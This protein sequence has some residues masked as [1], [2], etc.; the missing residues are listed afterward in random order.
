MVFT[1]ISRAAWDSTRGTVHGAR[2]GGRG[3][4]GEGVSPCL[5]MSRL[6]PRTWCYPGVQ[7]N[8]LAR[9]DF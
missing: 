8:L 1:P 6:Q 5:A 7:F 4:G 2:G 3:G 9:K